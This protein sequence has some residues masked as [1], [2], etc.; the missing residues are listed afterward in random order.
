[1]TVQDI[2]QL[3]GSLGFPIVCCGVMF[4][5]NSKQSHQHKEEAKGFSEALN[6]N[7]LALQKLVTL[8]EVQGNGKD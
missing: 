6:N 1:M 5:Q 4:W 8:M 3:I 2:T 7:T